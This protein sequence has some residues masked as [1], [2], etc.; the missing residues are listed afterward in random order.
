[1]KYSGSPVKPPSESPGFKIQQGVDDVLEKGLR[2]VDQKLLPPPKDWLLEKQAGPK[3]IA[4]RARKEGRS[5]EPHLW[6]R[7][8]PPRPVYP[9]DL[10]DA[11][12][13]ANPD[14]L[15]ADEIYGVSPAA[16]QSQMMMPGVAGA[17]TPGS[18]LSRGRRADVLKEVR[19]RQ[20]TRAN[21]DP[22]M[23]EVPH[24]HIQLSEEAGT[25][26]MPPPRE[27]TVNQRPPSLR[28]FPGEEPSLPPVMPRG[29]LGAPEPMVRMRSS[30]PMNQGSRQLSLYPGSDEMMPG[31][32]QQAPTEMLK[33]GIPEGIPYVEPIA[34]RAPIRPAMRDLTTEEIALIGTSLGTAGLPAVVSEAGQASRSRLKRALE[35]LFRRR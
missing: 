18:I 29:Q 7:D 10:E 1:V 20:F 32:A 6:N 26:I 11:F 27:P 25:E 13:D 19:S 4:K 31:V 5:V 33:Q 12:L 16:P 22:A 17:Q 30:R 24:G 35:A 9:D 23:P 28:S 8:F 21:T 14:R 3:T 15:A 34:A 2:E